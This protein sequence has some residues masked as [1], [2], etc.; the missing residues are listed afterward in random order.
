MKRGSQTVVLLDGDAD[1]FHSSYLSQGF[2][3]GTRAA[4]EL[5]RQVKAFIATKDGVA[6]STGCSDVLALCFLNVSGLENYLHLS[7]RPFVHGF[8]SSPFALSMV[9]TGG[10]SQS[11]DESLKS[12]DYLTFHITTT[13]YIL[14]GGTHDGGYAATLHRLDPELVRRKVILLRTTPFCAPRLADFGLEEATFPGLFQ[15]R[16]PRGPNYGRGGQQQKTLATELALASQLKLQSSSPSPSPLIVPPKFR[17]LVDHLEEL[18]RTGDARP[19][20]SSVG[21]QL[22]MVEPKLYST[23][24]KQYAAEAEKAG[25][26][27]FGGKGPESE[28]I[29]L[30]H[31]LTPAAPA[32]ELTPFQPLLMILRQQAQLG[33]RTP[34][35][36]FL[37]AQLHQLGSTSTHIFDRGGEGCATWLEYLEKAEQRGVVKTGGEREDKWVALK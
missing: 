6:G 32:H 35:A 13:D 7:L 20:R 22:G 37:Q 30:A 15:G 27:R 28:W 26:V 2:M 24:F 14:M 23:S 33:N 11:A 31:H 5:H 3:G 4:V 25:L 36:L 29:E 34:S 8:N 21:S 12:E 1:Y 9:D 19:L 18:R 16:D 10:R 17:G